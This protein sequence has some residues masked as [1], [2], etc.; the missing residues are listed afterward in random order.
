[1]SG[2]P[3]AA[4]TE[5]RRLPSPAWLA[6]VVALVI[7]GWLAYDTLSNRGPLITV[8]FADGTGLTAGRIAVR[9][10]AVDVGLTPDLNGVAAAIRVKPELADRL[11]DDARFWIVRSR[12]G[13]AQLSGLE[14]IVSGS[15]V[16]LDPGGSEGETKGRFAGLAGPPGVMNHDQPDL[17]GGVRN[18]LCLAREPGGRGG[19]GARRAGQDGELLSRLGGR[20]RAWRAGTA[21][22]AAR[23]HG[24]RRRAAARSARG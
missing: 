24:R 7:G 16:A 3:P 5:R 20:H 13:A 10:R 23:R 18:A 11:T 6:P 21:V 17:D 14:T 1:M 8:T 4:T 19:R 15:Y 9:Y 2:R 22:R 12:L